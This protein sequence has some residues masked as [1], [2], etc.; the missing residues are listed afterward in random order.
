MPA[1]G[2]LVPPDALKRRVADGIDERLGA[3]LAISRRLHRNPETAWRENASS[4]FL[5]DELAARGF[6]VE[7]GAAGL[8]TAFV[9]AYGEGPVTVGLVAEYDA[10]PGLGHAC[11]HNIIAATAV[12]AA[13]ALAGV[14]ADLGIGIRVLGA[15]AE[16]GGGGKIPMLE[17]GCFDDLAFAMMIHPGPADAVYARP[18]AVAHFDVTYRG[19]TAH[20]GAYPHLGR[21][22]AD[23][24]T[25]AQVAIGLLRQQLAP[26]VRVHGIVTEAGAAPN[27]I[28]DLARGAWY[29][30]ADTLAEL[31]GAFAR[32]RACFEAGAL[33]AGCEWELTETS[34]R[35]A[36]FRNDERLAT[37]FAANG[38]ALGRDMDLAENGPRGMA[39]ASTDMGNVSQRLRAI[40]PYLGIASLPAVNHQPAFAAAAVTQAAD[41]AVRD[42]AVLLAQTAIDAALADLSCAAQDR[43]SGKICTIDVSEPWIR[44]VRCKEAGIPEYTLRQLQYFVAAAEA[45][46]VTQAAEAVHLSQSAMSTALA[47]LE[48]AFQVQLL[49]RHHAR[50]ISLTPAGRELLVASRQLLAQA[51]DL[52]GAAE[53]LGNSLTGTVQIG[54]FS[55]PAPYVLPELLATAAE[56]F[57]GLQVETAEVNLAELAEGVANGR[58]ELGIGYDLIDDDRLTQHP[59]FSLPPYV[60]LPGTHRWSKRRSVRLAELAEEPMVLLDLPHS[61][62]YFQRIFSSAGV[63][64]T[65]RYRSASVETC[66]ALV[67]RGLA[68]TVLNLQPKVSVS[69]DGHP[70]AAVPIRDDAPALSVV[71]LTAANTRP[72]RRAQAIATLCRERLRILTE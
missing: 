7:R 51:A 27:A 72:T 3:L 22:A 41:R 21:N 43:I 52:L 31:D 44:H 15:P 19:V 10:L 58:F 17:A 11:G 12:G 39:T 68:Y 36:E 26:S 42:G 13:E 50:G 9:A 71:L 59:L 57:P 54:C 40:H 23:A 28:P 69:L 61:R 46:T 32:V 56:Q 45:G 70:V 6:A 2:P 4:A 18:R 30:R 16:E 53:G 24:F 8:P 38:A 67:G 64:P 35:Y 48:K 47:D 62:D 66:R 25:I 29:V 63:T 49:V 14:A 60:L 5:A 37:L 34:P 20:A 33:A 55:V 1:R 65:V